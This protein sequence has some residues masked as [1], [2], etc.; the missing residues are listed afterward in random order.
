MNELEAMGLYATCFIIDGQRYLLLPLV[1]QFGSQDSGFH[2][3]VGSRCLYA[4]M[5]HRH[6]RLFGTVVA[7]Q[8]SDDTFGFLPPALI[9]GEVAAIT[10]DAHAFAGTDALAPHTNRK[11]CREEELARP[12]WDI[13]VFHSIADALRIVSRDSCGYCYG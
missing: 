4:H 5:E 2:S 13:R 7:A 11:G 12:R 10:T 1:E 9:D 6:L 3:N 8:Y